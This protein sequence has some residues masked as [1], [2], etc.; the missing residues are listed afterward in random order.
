MMTCYVVIVNYKR[1]EDTVECIQSVFAS[2]YLGCKVLVVDN[3]SG[4]NS[5]E[6]IEEVF[7]ADPV[8]RSANG[9]P[10]KTIMVQGAELDTLDFS[11]LPDLLLVQHE[12][13]AGFAAGNN[14]VLQ[15]LQNKEA[16]LFLL[17]PDMTVHPQAI[18]KLVASATKQQNTVWGLTTISDYDKEQLLFYGGGRIRYFTAT[19]KPLRHWKPGIRIDYIS[20]GGLFTHCASFQQLGLLPEKYFLYWEE[21]DWCLQ[22]VQKKFRLNVCTDAICYDKISTVIGRGFQS[23]YYY[24]RNGLMFLKKYAR[25]ALPTAILA[26]VPR[27]IKRLIMGQW[28]RAR[29]VIKGV[30]DFFSATEYENQ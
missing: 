8:L 9:K 10:I 18:S 16:Y 11:Q 6:R 28:S 29:G 12:R 20:G 3:C 25:W 19:V 22:A 14:L 15:Y 17:N 24:T 13:N 7:S 30:V 2:D 5:L 23:D 27:T 21:T 4:N 1:W 26:T